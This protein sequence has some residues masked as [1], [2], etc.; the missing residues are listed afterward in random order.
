MILNDTCAGMQVFTTGS[1]ANH[2]PL[3]DES[4][5]FLHNSDENIWGKR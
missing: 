1:D 2:S 4:L 5:E 3:R